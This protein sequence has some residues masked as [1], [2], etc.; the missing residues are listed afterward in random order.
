MAENSLKSIMEFFG[1][2]ASE[3][4]KEWKLM[5]E[6]DKTQL[7]NGIRDGSLTY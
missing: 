2:S 6:Q 7:K 4:M 3:F 1:M 5:D